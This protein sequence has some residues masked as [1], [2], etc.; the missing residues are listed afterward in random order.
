MSILQEKLDKLSKASPAPMGFGAVAAREKPQPFLIIAAVAKGQSSL[1]GRVAEAGADLLLLEAQ[2]SPEGAP[3]WGMRVEE[4]RQEQLQDLRQRGC[5]FVIFPLEETQTAV[6]G[7]EEL[8]KVLQLGPGLSDST[9]RAISD[10]PLDAV[11][12]DAG[13]T[14]NTVQGL[15]E[16]I[17]VRQYCSKHLLAVVDVGI[18]QADL[19]ALQVAGVKGLLVPVSWA[20]DVE[21]LS[22]LKKT[23]ANLKPPK[24]SKERP[25]ALVP[26]LPQD[27]GPSRSAPDEPDEDE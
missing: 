21:K 27:R 26:Q 9:L 22:A 20:G 16:Y 15:L 17:R 5:D 25:S 7:A 3:P 2:A 8:G 19:E 4:A 24:R 23:I 6:L 11:V 12:L 1:A 10:L 18:S 14:L 13:A